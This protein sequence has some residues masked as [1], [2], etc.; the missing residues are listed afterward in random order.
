MSLPPEV[1][2]NVYEQALA[3]DG[4]IRMRYRRRRRTG[5]DLHP[6]LSSPRT[7]QWSEPSLLQVNKTIRSGASATYYKSNN[8]EM[9]I[10]MSDLKAASAWL[11]T[12]V[13]RCGT[14]PFGHFQFY[15]C[16][17]RWI[18][19]PFLRDFVQLFRDIDLQLPIQSPDGRTI[20]AW[21]WSATRMTH[22]L[23]WAL[24]E[25]VA[26]GKKARVEGWS[27][28]WLDVEFGLWAEEKQNSGQALEMRKKL[29]R[30]H[31]VKRQR[32][33]EAAKKQVIRST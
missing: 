31:E 17:L 23:D 3:E 19:L 16:N 10:Q 1:R 21:F 18:E 8:F 30:K 14:D 4:I 22:V 28:D 26:L 33:Q 20:T 9:T 29:R 5:H 7:D 32:A 13:A 24:A 12:I 25:A 15:L 11:R 2:N 27:E 6:E